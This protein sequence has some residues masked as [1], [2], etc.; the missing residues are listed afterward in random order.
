M[1]QAALYPLALLW[2]FPFPDN[3]YYHNPQ[4]LGWTEGAI[5]SVLER[6]RE[7]GAFDSV[8]P[9]TQ[10]HGVTLA[11]VYILGETVR[12]LDGD[13][14]PALG[15]AVRRAVRRACE[16]AL[17]SR[18][19]YSY[20]SNHWAMFAVAWLDAA[21]LLENSQFREHAEETVERILREQSPD[22]WYREYEGP[23]P[24]Y[25]SLGISYLATYWQR[26]GSP[27]LLDSLRRSIEFY[28]HFVHPDGSVGGVYASRYTSLYFPAGFEILAV[29]IPMAA[30]IAQFMRERLTL[31]NVVTPS[32][33]DPENLPPLVSNYLEA[34]LVP[35][36]EYQVE[37]P[38]LPCGALEGIRHFP[39]SGLTVTGTRH[40]YAV[41]N[42]S[43]G[44]VCRIFDKHTNKIAYEDAGYFVRA[45]GRCWNSQFIGL[46][47]RVDS[48]RTDEVACKTT[49]AEVR[50]ELPTP[51]KFVLL[52]I[53]NLT[54]FRSLA[55]GTWIRRL[56]VSRLITKKRPGLL[57]LTRLVRFE[58]DEIQF[59]DRL[60][61]THPMHVEEVELP[62][63][64][65]ATHMGSAKYFHPSQLDVTPQVHGIGMASDLNSGGVANCE[66]TLHF[67]LTSR[68]ELV[69]GPAAGDA[70][71][72][73]M[74]DS[75]HE[76]TRTVASL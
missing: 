22:G 12:L 19:D 42:A 64:F 45:G 8:G 14:T 76:D 21:E 48:S 57:L 7:N 1:S 46:G 9:F 60:E 71:V 23:D 2:R 24:G 13:L 4:V 17:L 11:M 47:H 41:I 55:L 15:D 27:R 63:S 3:P 69:I 29:E 18:E 58:S 26:T 16:F 62:R 6:Q 61:M 70:K 35:E 36:I 32:V 59:R 28:T 5:A 49:L 51:A 50:Q 31:H 72:P 30:A 33:S 43:K 44:G 53:L 73:H 10:D 25:E 54:L 74:E 56:I 52:R 67:S 65:M 39:D 37:V 38:P 68:P 66:F 75:K 40:Y 20:I 34:C